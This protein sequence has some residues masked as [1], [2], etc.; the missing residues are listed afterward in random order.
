MLALAVH[1]DLTSVGL[2][3]VR[4]C[5]YPFLFWN[6]CPW[7]GSS[8]SSKRPRMLVL[9]TTPTLS[10]GKSAHPP[11][12]GASNKT[13]AIP[14]G[15]EYISFGDKKSK[16]GASSK[17]NPDSGAQVSSDK[18]KGKVAAAAQDDG[19]KK[20]TA[21][22]VIGGASWT[23]KLPQNLFNEHCQRAKWERPDYTM[24]KVPSIVT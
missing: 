6:F 9:S 15:S 22:E 12:K 20:P 24:V 23:G 4:L 17:A 8:S 19:P 10:M 21:R 16:G 5:G 14:E 3:A 13:S 2:C 7:A 11:R 18:G 1:D